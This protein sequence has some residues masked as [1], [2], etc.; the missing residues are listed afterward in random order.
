[1]LRFGC[2]Y[3]IFVAWSRTVDLALLFFTK[4]KTERNKIGKKKQKNRSSLSPV[5]NR[6]GIVSIRRQSKLTL[7]FYGRPNII[8]ISRTLQEVAAVWHYAR[9]DREEFYRKDRLINISSH[10]CHI[11]SQQICNAR[12]T[13]NQSMNLLNKRTDRP[14]TLTCMNTCR[15]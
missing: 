6:K 10:N 4:M 1:M 15:K 2:A 3:Q 14:L 9:V 8:I 5:L 11:Q 13:I 7:S 12:H